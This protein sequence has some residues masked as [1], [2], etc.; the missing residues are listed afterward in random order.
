MELR[1]GHASAEAELYVRIALRCF[2][3]GSGNSSQRRL[4]LYT[5]PAG[6]WR[7]DRIVCY[8]D[9]ADAAAD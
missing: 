5:M 6:E 1:A 7:G 3:P 8:V 2:V 4:I 9:S